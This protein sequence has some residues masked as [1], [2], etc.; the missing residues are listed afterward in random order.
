MTESLFVDRYVAR[1]IEYSPDK[2]V[3]CFD[4]DEQFYLV[5]RTK[6]A[7][8]VKVRWSNHPQAPCSSNFEILKV[9]G[10]DP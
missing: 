6:K 9:P 1:G 7:S 5:D 2:F 8:L 10:F 4:Q 3:V